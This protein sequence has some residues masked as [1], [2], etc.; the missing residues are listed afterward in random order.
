ME[1]VSRW[2]ELN[3]G[4]PKR[5]LILDVQGKRDMLELALEVMLDEG[6]ISSSVGAKGA[7][8]FTVDRLYREFDD[9][10]AHPRT[11]R[12]PA[13]HSAAQSCRAPAHPPLQGVRDGARQS[14]D[15]EDVSRAPSVQQDDFEF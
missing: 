13:A 7:K 8:F 6:W 11:S 15:E 14:E 9:S 12:A 1:R 10:A 2:L 4:V 5:Q 3:P